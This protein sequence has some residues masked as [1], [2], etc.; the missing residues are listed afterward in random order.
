MSLFKAIKRKFG[1]V[2]KNSGYNTFSL[3]EK[4]LFPHQVNC[5]GTGNFLQI[6][7]DFQAKKLIVDIRGDNNSL[8]IGDHFRS[9]GIVTV[10][11][12]GSGNKIILDDNIQVIE[13]LSIYNQQNCQY[14]SLTIGKGCSFYSTE[15]HLYDNKS[16]IEIGD[17][18]IF[19]YNA[20]IHHTDGHGIFENGKLV[21]QAEKCIIGSH[22]WVGRNALI[23][24][25]SE[26]PDGCIIAANSVI[27]KKFLDKNAVITSSG[28]I[29]KGIE[30]DRRSVN[31]ILKEQT[32]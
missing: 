8:I 10:S 25:N 2:I 32:D 21:N 27:A 29:K 30:W 9:S 28:V 12:I 4:L 31:D 7:H 17:D 19:A 26:I 22:V 20:V 5:C 24:K 18:C 14:G 1:S 23:L 16:S 13:R 15:I 11:I 3:S 6:G